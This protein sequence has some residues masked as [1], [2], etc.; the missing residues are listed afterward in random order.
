MPHGPACPHAWGSLSSQCNCPKIVNVSNDIE[1]VDPL[2]RPLPPA[3]P[4]TWKER[5][6]RVRWAREN[7]TPGEAARFIQLYHNTTPSIRYSDCADLI[8]KER[9]AC[10]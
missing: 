3:P 10:S 8:A 5:E 1:P 2:T 9:K 7:F 6:D 4:P